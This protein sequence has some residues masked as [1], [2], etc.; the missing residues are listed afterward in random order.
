MAWLRKMPMYAVLLLVLAGLIGGAAVG[1]YAYATFSSTVVTGQQSSAGLGEAY[2]WR[3]QRLFLQ[4]ASGKPASS[5]VIREPNGA[6][7]S[8]YVPRNSSKGF[9]NTPDF[10]EVAPRPGVTATMRCSETVDVTAGDSAVAR[11]KTVKSPLFH[12]GVPALITIPVLLALVVPTLRR[13]PGKQS[14]P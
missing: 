12:L 9:L 2:E 14:A 3:G 10:V 7:R 6:Q 1:Y 13:T 11:A 8:V 5:C 4:T